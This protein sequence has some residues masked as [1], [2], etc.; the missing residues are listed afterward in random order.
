MVKCHEDVPHHIWGLFQALCI[1]Y[2]WI[3]TSSAL[4]RALV[5]TDDLAIDDDKEAAWMALHAHERDLLEDTMYWCLAHLWSEFSDTITI[6]IF[7]TNTSSQQLC[8]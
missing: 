5:T 8:A 7:D 2:S 1:Q 3:L 4:G 6:T